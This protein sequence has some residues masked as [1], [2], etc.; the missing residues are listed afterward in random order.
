MAIERIVVGVDGSTGSARALALVAELATATGASVVAVHAFEPLALIGKVEPP[1]DFPKIK[2]ETESLL[3]DEW[4]RVL[5]EAGVEFRGVV[6]D[7]D[8]VSAL[9][10]TVEAEHADL[11]VVGTRGLGKAKALVLG[12]VAGKLPSRSPV[13][14]T[15]VPAA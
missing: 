7:A 1:L 4:C 2:R 12:S 10:G 8:P 13:P 11:V 6:V 15:I 5:S 14:V 3:R 9:I